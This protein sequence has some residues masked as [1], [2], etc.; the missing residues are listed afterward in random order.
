M[1]YL[2]STADSIDC[3]WKMNNRVSEWFIDIAKDRFCHDADVA[4]QLRVSFYING[5]A[6]DCLFEKN[7]ELALRCRD[8]LRVVAEEVAEGSW[9]YIDLSEDAPP[10]DE[11]AFRERFAELSALLDRWRPEDL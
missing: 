7:P 1:S 10:H 11:A 9:Q 4:E 3:S 2:I 8:A 5:L 6:L